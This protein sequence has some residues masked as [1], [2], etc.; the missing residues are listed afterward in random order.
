MELK[1][2]EN[3][4]NKIEDLQLKIISSQQEYDEV[5]KAKI[6]MDSENTRLNL[7]IDSIY[8]EK[9]EMTNNLMKYEENSFTNQQD[10]DIF[11]NKANE[12]KLKFD[13]L[14]S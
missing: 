3:Y 6:M 14:E 2:L 10:L 9:K 13:Q 11:R 8:S 12:L 5:K 1:N 4:K 7:L